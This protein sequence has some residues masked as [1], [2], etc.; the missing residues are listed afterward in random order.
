[1]ASNQSR[2]YQDEEWL[3]EKYVDDGVTPGEMADECDVTKESIFR[4]LEIYGLRRRESKPEPL[5]RDCEHCGEKFE[6]PPSREGRKKYCSK[7]CKHESQKERKDSTCEACGET[8]TTRPCEIRKFC[9]P[10]CNGQANRNRVTLSCK[11]CGSEYE[12]IASEAE[13]SSFCSRECQFNH[14]TVELECESCGESFERQ[15]N[16]VG[17]SGRDFCTQECF[18]EWSKKEGWGKY[19]G[20]NLPMRGAYWNQQRDRALSRDG[21]ECQGCGASESLTVHHIRRRRTFDSESEAHA[22]TNLVTLCRPCHGRR[23]SS[24]SPG[25]A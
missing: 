19:Q 20:D 10:A 17:R 15:R 16:L 2:P 22:L 7:K 25:T 3:R 8:F 23:E 6:Y 18:R 1:M 9:S 14:G 4:W 12:V 24:S 5:T 11:E 13:G 21:Y